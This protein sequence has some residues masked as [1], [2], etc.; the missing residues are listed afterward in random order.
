MGTQDNS[1]PKQI[2][3]GEMI[4][5]LSKMP[6]RKKVR[7]LTLPHSYR[8][9]YEHLAFEWM[10]T[11]QGASFISAK[12]VLSLAKKALGKTFQGY[13]G[14]EYKMTADTPV[15]LAMEGCEGEMLYGLDQQTGNWITEDLIF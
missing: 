10:P 13:K 8:G 12:E 4:S 9:F 6:P 3:L 5:L 14:G 1:K 11:S 7:A 15:W 2:T